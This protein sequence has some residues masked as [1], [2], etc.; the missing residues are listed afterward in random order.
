MENYASVTVTRPISSSLQEVS[1]WRFREQIARYEKT[2]ALQARL[3][4]ELQ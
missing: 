3:E 4:L 2:P 1:T